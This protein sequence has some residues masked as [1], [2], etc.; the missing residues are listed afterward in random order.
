MKG[1]W[2]SGHARF[3]AGVHS[4]RIMVEEEKG[5]EKGGERDVGCI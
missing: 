2:S 4:K 3:N 5:G 1:G